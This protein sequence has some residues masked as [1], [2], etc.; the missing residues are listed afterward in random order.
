M[1]GHNLRFSISLYNLRQKFLISDRRA[2]DSKQQ[3]VCAI[4][5]PVKNQVKIIKKN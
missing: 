4:P 3:T 5:N 1:I 2:R